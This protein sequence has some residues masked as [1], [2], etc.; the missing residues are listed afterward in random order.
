MKRELKKII[1]GKIKTIITNECYCWDFVD[2]EVLTSILKLKSKE[3]KITIVTE[4]ETK[5]FL[6]T[7]DIFTDVLIIRDILSEVFN[8]GYKKDEISDV[9]LN[10]VNVTRIGKAYR[11]SNDKDSSEKILKEMYLKEI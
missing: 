2:L 7:D 6:F 11:N 4:N 8:L 10:G 9:F 1:K 3:N 5:H